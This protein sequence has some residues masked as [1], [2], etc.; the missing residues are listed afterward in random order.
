MKSLTREVT[1]HIITDAQGG[2]LIPVFGVRTPHEIKEMK[3][4]ILWNKHFITI[5][6][7]SIFYKA[8]ASRGIQILNHFLDSHGALFPFEN[9]KSNRGR[10]SVLHICAGRL[11]AIP[12]N[13]IHIALSWQP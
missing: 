6:G 7:K 10:C 11:A 1:A 5:G 2:P 3:E 12:K 4:G 13:Y 9:F 8:W